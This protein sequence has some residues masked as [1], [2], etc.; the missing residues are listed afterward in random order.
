MIG[1]L[2]RLSKSGCRIYAN[3]V[4]NALF[5]LTLCWSI[6]IVEQAFEYDRLADILTYLGIALIPLYLWRLIYL[7]SFRQDSRLFV[8]R[9]FNQNNVAWF[10]L[11]C[12]T[13]T[14][15]SIAKDFYLFY[16]KNLDIIPTGIV[17]K[18]LDFLF[19]PD[20]L[21]WSNISFWLVLRY[22]LIIM[23]LCPY[24]I[25][26]NNIFHLQSGVGKHYYKLPTPQSNPSQNGRFSENPTVYPQNNSFNSNNSYQTQ[27]QR[28]TKNNHRH[29]KTGKKLTYIE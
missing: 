3:I 28:K 9:N 21:S 16:S 5:P 8:F 13:V 10:G 7:L 1:T 22:L 19:Q 24:I 11:L 6:N 4:I 29:G 25:N 14:I 18:Y 23:S 26:I 2:F 12:A 27:T 17:G 20:L 15:I